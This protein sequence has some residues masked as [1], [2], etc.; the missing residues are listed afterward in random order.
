M[1]MDYQQRKILYF[2]PRK[3]APYHFAR[4]TRL[5]ETYPHLV[6]GNILAP[7]DY[8]QWQHDPG[9]LADRIVLIGNNPE[10]ADTKSKIKEVIKLLE[11]QKPEAIVLAGYN[12]PT[13]I[14][15]ARW[16]KKNLVPRI[17]QA[18]SWYG[19]HPRYRLK[20][21]IKKLFFVKPHFDAAFVPGM[22]GFQYINSLGIKEDAIW[23][24]LNIVDN[25]YFS[26]SAA[27]VVKDREVW[28]KRFGLPQDYFL[29]VA[30]LCPEKNMLRLL[31]AFRRY[32]DAGGPWQLVI[33][34]TGPEE[35]IL[36]NYVAA[37]NDAGILFA[38]W[39]HYEE[40]P[41]YYG[42]AKCFILPSL[43]E[44]W[45][46]VVNE[47]MACGLPVLVSRKCG[48][49][50]ELCHRGINGFDFEP[51]DLEGLAS[52]MLKVSSGALDLEAMGA[53]SRRIISNFTL[54]TWVQALKDCIETTVARLMRH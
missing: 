40:L 24:G 43:T 2:T 45:G 7:G 12:D 35:T 11:Q 48:C 31:Q 19:D 23:R 17:L 49:F 30:R 20:E 27:A 53:A 10:A 5:A 50:P 18:D 42:L 52:L 9:E 28:R 3:M 33:I 14:A 29:A 32:R 47:A 6:I 22:R 37:R 21:L 16:A 39:G 4:F 13:Q 34:G 15:A 8:R 51:L 1:H 25:D 46:L 38:G 41:V 36:K 26:R 44:P 54:D